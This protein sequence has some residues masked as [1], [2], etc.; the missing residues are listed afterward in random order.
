MK[1]SFDLT[2]KDLAL[3]NALNNQTWNAEVA[4]GQATH[5]YP[6]GYDQ[7]YYWYSTYS[8]STSSGSTSA[9]AAP[10]SAGEAA[11]VGAVTTMVN[12]TIAVKM[13]KY[14]M[15]FVLTGNP[16]TM[17]ADDKIYW[18][19]YNESS[20][21]TQIVFNDTFTVADDDLANAKSLFWNKALWY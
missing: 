20:V 14:L 3:T 10:L 16:N 11:S 4:L 7:N 12:A 8:L 2:P 21:G 13:Q 6:H 15:S 19:L 18:P 5:G 17:W 1:Q 9:T